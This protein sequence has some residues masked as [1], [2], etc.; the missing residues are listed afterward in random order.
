MKSRLAIVIILIA[1]AS[2]L[3]AR[4]HRSEQSDR[5]AIE[6]LHQL[7]LQTTLTD[8]ADEL[9]RLWDNNAVRIQP[10]GSV[11]IGKAKIYADDKRWEEKTG[12]SKTLCY[13][14]EIQDVRIAGEWAFEWGYFSYKDSSNPQPARGKVLRI[15]KRQADGSWKFTHVAAVPEK[16]GSAAPMSHPCE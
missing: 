4:E 7:D 5:V 15:M 8:K 3:L 6:R 14:S 2:V 10:G 9:A 13:K 12:R 16:V 11:E 1:V